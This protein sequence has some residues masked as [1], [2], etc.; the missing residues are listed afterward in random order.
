MI[1]GCMQMENMKAHDTP[2]KEMTTRKKDERITQTKLEEK[3]A[4]ACNAATKETGNTG[5][6]HHTGNHPIS[7]LPGHDTGTGTGT[8]GIYS[9]TGD[10]GHPTGT[11]PTSA[12]PGHGTGQPAVQVIE[13]VV[14]S[15][16]IATYTAAVGRTAAQ[17]AH[18]DPRV[19]GNAPG[20][21]TGE[22]L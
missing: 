12:L 1:C 6:G 13:V 14:G 7:A 18:H 15:Q 11:H 16:P 19:E 22:P 5:T 4:R 9:T 17:P 3:Q 10:T 20:Y 2:Q 21:G 8:T